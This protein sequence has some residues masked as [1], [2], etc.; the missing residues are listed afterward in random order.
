MRDGHG[1]N[2]RLPRSDR[3]ADA[4]GGSTKRPKTNRG[5]YFLLDREPKES[6]L[7]SFDLEVIGRYFA[8]YPAALSEY[9]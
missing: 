8:D 1:A 7:R 3:A 5:V 4:V 2:L 9:L 6:I